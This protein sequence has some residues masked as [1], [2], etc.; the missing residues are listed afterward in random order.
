MVGIAVS[1]AVT[2]TTGPKVKDGECLSGKVQPW[3][4]MEDG[5]KATVMS[6]SLL[7]L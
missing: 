1:V 2:V 3:K 6:W 5:F 7:E 4:K